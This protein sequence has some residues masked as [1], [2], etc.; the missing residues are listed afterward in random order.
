MPKKKMGRPE[1]KNPKA[2]NK[3]I[4][5]DEKTIAKVEKYCKVNN[6]SFAE[7]IRRAIDKLIK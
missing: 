4:R 6:L 2:I 1:V 3:T 7:A 5:F